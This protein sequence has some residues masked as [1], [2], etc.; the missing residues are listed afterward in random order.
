MYAGGEDESSVKNSTQ[1]THDHLNSRV[2]GAAHN[3]QLFCF[4]S[5]PFIGRKYSRDQDRAAAPCGFVA[6][7]SPRPQVRSRPYPR[8][9]GRAIL[10][11]RPPMRTAATTWSSCAANWTNW[12]TKQLTE[13]SESC[14]QELLTLST[15]CDLVA[16]KCVLAAWKVL[17][18]CFFCT[19]CSLLLYNKCRFPCLCQLFRIRTIGL[20]YRVKKCLSVNQTMASQDTLFDLGQGRQQQFC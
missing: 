7:P 1:H 10:G 11:P 6:C 12:M 20:Q 19:L 2:F 15:W 16:G 5:S 18:T 3:L 4:S 14:E 8:H 9:R 13:L 17:S